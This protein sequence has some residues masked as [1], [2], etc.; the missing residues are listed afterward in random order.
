MEGQEQDQEVPSDTTHNINGDSE[1]IP[2]LDGVEKIL[3]YKFNNKSLL[4][5]AFTDPSYPEK[6]FSYER[7]EYLGDSVLNLLF[8]KEQYFLY[9]DL[10]P[11]SLTRLRSANVNTEK[12]ARVAIKL[13][14]HHYLRHNK[15]LL[16][17]QVSAQD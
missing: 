16:E 5:E 2:N 11:G 7:L 15:P 17:E 4:E 12:L 9:P 13:G 8:T 10:P 14:L 1:S 3:G 6:C